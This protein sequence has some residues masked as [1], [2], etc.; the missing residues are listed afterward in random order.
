MFIDNSQN[1]DSEHLTSNFQID[2]TERDLTNTGI[3]PTPLE[4]DSTTSKAEGDSTNAEGDSTNSKR[5]STD[6]PT[7]NGEAHGALSDDDRPGKEE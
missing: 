6:S 7:K 1:V 5:H 2:D 3:N 4:G